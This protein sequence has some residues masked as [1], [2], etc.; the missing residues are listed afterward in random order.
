MSK[1]T[2]AAIFGAT[3]VIAS[4]ARKAPEPEPEPVMLEPVM[5]EPVATK[6]K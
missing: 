4:C 1:L 2:I 6:S 3:L 5:A